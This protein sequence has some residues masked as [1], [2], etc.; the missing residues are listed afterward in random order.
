MMIRSWILTAAEFKGL[1]QPEEKEH[2]P[3]EGERDADQHGGDRAEGQQIEQ[4]ARAERG[5]DG[6]RRLAAGE[7]VGPLHEVIER[8][9]WSS[10]WFS[11]CNQNIAAWPV[12][13][14]IEI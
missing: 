11:H 2:R 9:R 6:L 1:E 7:F 12:L 4:E 14:R 10:C 8:G 13:A 5:D 3:D